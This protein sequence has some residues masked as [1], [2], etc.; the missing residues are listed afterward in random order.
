MDD[1]TTQDRVRYTGVD[2]IVLKL[3]VFA[4]KFFAGWFIQP[5]AEF[6]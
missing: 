5:G 2:S 1:H 3:R 6:D 4:G